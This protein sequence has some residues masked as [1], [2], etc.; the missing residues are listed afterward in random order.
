[1]AARVDNLLRR[2]V[3][4]RGPAPFVLRDVEVDGRRSLLGVQLCGHHDHD[5]ARRFTICGARDADNTLTGVRS[6][7]SSGAT[8]SDGIKD[9]HLRAC[10][11][12]F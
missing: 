8:K 5:R 10:C 12:A 6:G 3:P 4:A 11:A 1:M 2:R 9:A 7:N